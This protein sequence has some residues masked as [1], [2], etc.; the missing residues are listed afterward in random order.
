M[1][2]TLLDLCSNEEIESFI[3][4]KIEVNN[5]LKEQII[6]MINGSDLSQEQKDRING[7]VINT[8]VL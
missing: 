5:I 1:S 7:K 3:C 8:L 2:K 4:S 6:N